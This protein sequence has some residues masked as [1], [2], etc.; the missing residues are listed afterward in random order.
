MMCCTIEKCYSPRRTT[1]NLK[2]EYP[3]FFFCSSE[4]QLLQYTWMPEEI[5]DV[6][7]IARSSVDV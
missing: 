4:L 7:S 6:A 2:N 5:V 3:T 1:K